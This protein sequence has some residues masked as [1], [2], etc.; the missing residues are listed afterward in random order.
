MKKITNANA[1]NA[2]ITA[3]STLSA[4]ISQEFT[5]KEILEK[6]LTMLE[7]TQRKNSGERKPTSAQIENDRIRNEILQKMADG[8]LRTTSDVRDL[9]GMAVETTPQRIA[10]LLRPLV[11][12]GK[13]V[14][15]T[16]KRKVYYSIPGVKVEG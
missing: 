2:A 11:D 14:K 16:I 6:L 12:E 3:L 15:H 8:V 4:P 5:N 1:L 13:L 9:M 7:S 10:G